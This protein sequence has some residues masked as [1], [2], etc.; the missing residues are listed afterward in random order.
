MASAPHTLTSLADIAKNVTDWVNEVAALTQPERIHWCDG[1]PSEFQRLRGE[2]E[3][4]GDLHRLNHETF[5]GCYLYR[6]DPSDVARVEHLTFVCTSTAEEAGP[7]NNWLAPAVAHARMRELFK[8][9][10]RGRILYVIPYCMGPIN[11]PL[12]T[13]WGGNHRQR[14][15]GAQHVAS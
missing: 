15:C 6:S 13:L 8:G 5:P 11:S 10:M 14:L 3:T 12:F 1:T 7:N 9:C 4:K 2:L